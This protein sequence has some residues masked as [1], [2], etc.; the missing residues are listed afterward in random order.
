MSTRRPRTR[1][2]SPAAGGPAAGGSTAAAA[3]ASKCPFA[4]QWDQR[5]TLK[6][7]P[8]TGPM[9]RLLRGLDVCDPECAP[10]PAGSAPRGRRGQV[11]PRSAQCA[12]AELHHAWLPTAGRGAAQLVHARAPRAI[13]NKKKQRLVII[14]NRPDFGV[15]CVS[16][17]HSV[18]IL[19]SSGCSAVS[20]AILIAIDCR[21]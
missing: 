5:E 16:E 12:Q 1:S 7:P 9:R 11:S 3:S 14:R 20:S 19:L 15:N 6:P 21:A 4:A 18:S 2:R 8:F 13:E 10:P 17:L